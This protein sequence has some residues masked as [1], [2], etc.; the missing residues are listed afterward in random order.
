M[1]CSRKRI[2]VI[3]Q[4]SDFQRRAV[5][6][7]EM[8]MDVQGEP[9][10]LQPTVSQQIVLQCVPTKFVLSD[11]SV[12]HAVSHKLYNILDYHD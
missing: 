11:L 12:T 9:K 7:Q 6:L 3:Q 1:F 8:M 4:C 2:D 10:K 5:G